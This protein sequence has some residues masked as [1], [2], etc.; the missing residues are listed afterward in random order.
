MT[1]SYNPSPIHKNFSPSTVGRNCPIKRLGRRDVISLR[2]NNYIYVRQGDALNLYSSW[3][4]PQVIISDGAYG[5]LGF[6]G[7][8]SDHIGL[9]EWY[10][11]HIAAWTEKST[12]ATTLWFWNSEIGWATIHPILEKYGWKYINTNI[13]N[14]GKGHIAGNI[15]TTKIRRFPV[16]TE[17]CVQYVRNATI[18]GRELKNWLRYEWMRSGLA[19][20]KANIACGVSNA[21]S[22]KYFDQ[23]HLWYFPPPEV[24]IKMQQYA[25]KYG[26]PAGRPYFSLDGKIPC[27]Q[28]QWAAMRAKF[29]CPHGVTN[30]WNRPSL[31]GA[32]RIKIGGKTGKAI[33]L[34]QKPLDLM[35]MII[36]AS[37]DKGDTIW[38]P[39]GGL[40]TA[41]I[42]AAKIKRK[43]FGAEI[44]PIYYYYGVDRINQEFSQHSLL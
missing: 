12:P 39:F 31:R 40:F 42:A 23:G 37:S 20:H 30:V 35:T 25:N 13:W 36:E 2:D 4:V 6:D 14:K 21:A 8:T 15:N 29:H 11:P 27:S 43:S 3:D 1:N 33:H 22:R 16:V 26:N 17:L 28:E 32:E 38:E 44:N 18:G 7:D 5:V 41:C 24:F 34:N 19:M 10:E 9:Q